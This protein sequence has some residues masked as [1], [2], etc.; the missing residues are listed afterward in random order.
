MHRHLAREVATFSR[1]SEYR[2]SMPRGASAQLRRGQ[3]IDHDRRLLPLELVDG[4]DARARN[5]LLQLKNLGV[6]RRDDQDV[7]HFPAGAA[8]LSLSNQVV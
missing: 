2:N 5:A 8:K 1:L 3:R 7:G 4:A 6:V